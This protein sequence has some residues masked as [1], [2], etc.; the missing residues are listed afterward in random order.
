MDAWEILRLRRNAILAVTDRSQLLDSDSE[1]R[2][3]LGA[4]RQALRDL[5]ENTEDP[6]SP[7]WPEIPE[8]D[9]SIRQGIELVIAASL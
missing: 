3:A 9:E 2:A 4:Y 8:C 6:E 5:P 7:S 1:K